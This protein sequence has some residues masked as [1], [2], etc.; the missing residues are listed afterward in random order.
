MA[1][2][3]LLSGYTASLADCL[4]TELNS[5]ADA[6]ISGLGTAITNSSNLDMMI[7]FQID[8]ASLT[9][10]STTAYVIVYLV[11][12][13]DG[14]NYPDWGSTTYANYDAQYAVG[15]IAIKNVSAAAAKAVLE[16][17]VRLGP[18]VYKAAVRNMTGAAF[19]ASGNTLKYRTYAA[20]YT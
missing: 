9:I 18:G 15:P 19:A 12:A 8:L 17:T 11:P 20:S 2:D 5:L 7:D 16:G 10:S 13:L 1:G 3:I 4:T 6:A 14:T